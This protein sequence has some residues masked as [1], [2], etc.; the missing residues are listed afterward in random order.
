MPKTPKNKNTRNEELWDV[1]AKQ[2]DEI[3]RESGEFLAAE[4][5]EELKKE[6]SNPVILPDFN[7]DTTPGY[8]DKRREPA[9]LPIPWIL[10]QA[11]D[12]KE[13]HNEK[14]GRIES[15]A[16][17]RKKEPIKLPD[18][19]DETTPGYRPNPL[20]DEIP[21]VNR[22]PLVEEN[23]GISLIDQLDSKLDDRPAP[24]SGI[25]QSNNSPSHLQEPEKG[26][27]V[28]IPAPPEMHEDALEAA[29]SMTSRKI[30]GTLL[31]KEP[32]VITIPP[33]SMEDI[34]QEERFELLYETGQI[35]FSGLITD[36]LNS[37]Q[38]EL[39]AKIK[40]AWSV[41]P[42]HNS[43]SL[44]EFLLAYNFDQGVI[45][46][47]QENLQDLE[48]DK[49]FKVTLRSLYSLSREKNDNEHAKKCEAAIKNY[50]NTLRDIREKIYQG[51]E[52]N[53][54][55]GLAEQRLG[56]LDLLKD[57]RVQAIQKEDESERKRL[58]NEEMARAEK[59]RA[60]LRR[61]LSLA[62]S[63]KVELAENIEVIERIKELNKEVERITGSEDYKALQKHGG[64]SKSEIRTQVFDELEAAI[65][66]IGENLDQILN[67]YESS[68]SA[69][70]NG[71]DNKKNILETEGYLLAQLERGKA[72]YP[73]QSQRLGELLNKRGDIE[74]QKEI[75]SL[76]DQYEACIIEHSQQD[77]KSKM[78]LIKSQIQELSINNPLDIKRLEDLINAEEDADI[79]RRN[80]EAGNCLDD[81]DSLLELYKLEVDRKSELAGKT[82][83]LIEELENKFRTLK[84]TDL[85]LVAKFK[86]LAKNRKTAQKKAEMNEKITRSRQYMKAHAEGREKGPSGLPISGIL[87]ETEPDQKAIKERRKMSNLQ[88]E[89]NKQA[90]EILDEYLFYVNASRTQLRYPK[91][92]EELTK[93]VEDD[94]R[95]LDK[96][97]VY[98]KN[99]EKYKAQAQKIIKKWKETNK[100]SDETE[101]M[102]SGSLEAV[103]KV[104][105]DEET[106][107]ID[108]RDLAPLAK[109]K[110]PPI[111]PEILKTRRASRELKDEMNENDR[112]IRA[113]R[114]RM[115]S[116]QNRQR[117][118]AARL[119]REGTI[120][121]SKFQ[122]ITSL[123]DALKLKT[124][125]TAEE[126]LAWVDC[127]IE[128]LE[129]KKSIFSWEIKEITQVIES[130][131]S[132]KD[133]DNYHWALIKK[134]DRIQTL[135][136][137]KADEKTGAKKATSHSLNSNRGGLLGTLME[138]KKYLAKATYELSDSEKDGIEALSAAR[139]GEL[140]WLNEG[141]I[142][143][144]GKE[145]KPSAYEVGNTEDIDL[146]QARTI[147]LISVKEA[148]KRFSANDLTPEM[149]LMKAKMLM[150]AE[151]GRDTHFISDFLGY[152]DDYQ[153]QQ[154]AIDKAV[155]EAEKAKK[156]AE[157]KA[158]NVPK[159]SWW[160]RIKN[161]L[162]GKKPVPP[163]P[164]PA[165]PKID[166]II[167]RHHQ[168]PA[169]ESAYWLFS[170]K[171]KETQEKDK[172]L[173]TYKAIYEQYKKWTAEDFK[174][175]ARQ[176]KMPDFQEVKA[177][178]DERDGYMDHVAKGIEERQK[179]KDREPLALG[180]SKGNEPLVEAE[181]RA[182]QLSDEIQPEA[183]YSYGEYQRDL[184]AK[185]STEAEAR[186]VHMEY[187]KHLGVE[188]EPKTENKGPKAVA[189]KSAV[190]ERNERR[191]A[192]KEQSEVNVLE[193]GDEVWE[194]PG[195]TYEEPLEKT[196]DKKIDALMELA[197]VSEIPNEKLRLLIA[198]LKLETEGNAA[199]RQKRLENRLRK[200]SE[201]S[202][203]EGDK[204]Q[205]L[206][207]LVS[208]EDRLSA[209]NQL[210]QRL[211]KSNLN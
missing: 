24:T 76:L 78:D 50:Q 157:V 149:E 181:T 97:S 94:L 187:L 29:T 55:Y 64:D 205:E 74:A 47:I 194:M 114:A 170:T 162:T 184:A 112:N 180:E 17:D 80:K 137:E 89:I 101:L 70:E 191:K 167:K 195:E 138:R 52:I 44:E 58:A 3:G 152:Y 132:L 56:R 155:E 126:N 129:T 148:V 178:L 63:L 136:D 144:Y 79:S 161:R 86:N 206:N 99:F 189:N 185:K 41:I 143:D 83:E 23:N 25:I 145:V 92:L 33:L 160:D 22:A 72:S 98:I 106:R 32:S 68:L 208:N 88:V 131:V 62:R 66:E 5:D 198:A 192:K 15:G 53:A 69:Y 38:K 67:D 13:S 179:R 1:V 171:E 91:G 176:L 177:G 146:S 116:R 96:D 142:K 183:N 150:Q 7:G 77:Q 36:Q 188:D 42:K 102:G 43:K 49:Y 60:K 119:K 193:R 2:V 199:R 117:R 27:S 85:D 200:I 75:K 115:E 37:D 34:E 59:T 90:R 172:I 122:R 123:R 147:N 40:E 20:F 174:A 11:H 197:E 209:F 166:R 211:N 165:E 186:N 108:I 35:Y 127:I 203:S 204:L 26:P 84:P 31:K 130:L 107:P 4:P 153:G 196:G 182:I 8:K 120:D 87:S 133:D 61:I 135:I 45:S 158:K 134:A 100:D 82:L 175:F 6:A 190:V 14:R 30:D 81:Y 118:L 164:T 173:K 110:K 128:Q 10:K 207:N 65:L 95:G 46:S 125:N 104:L 201:G 9:R 210:T 163:T 159:L 39:L 51:E 154:K 73:K 48:K 28:V 103:P 12:N 139:R 18:F 109:N 57:L 54:A 156:E 113:M 202:T 93:I 21:T 124:F 71:E 141:E 169:E 121:L 105:E 151:R 19:E 16:G 111:R 140:D 168:S